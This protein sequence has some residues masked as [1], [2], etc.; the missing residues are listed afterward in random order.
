MGEI[1]TGEFCLEGSGS[2][3]RKSLAGQGPDENESS[4]ESS[5]GRSGEEGASEVPRITL[6]LIQPSRDPWPNEKFGDGPRVRRATGD[7]LDRDPDVK[8]LFGAK[9][10]CC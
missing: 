10:R 3:W 6:A 2:P 1:R 7:R 5:G 9:D 4:G 8:E